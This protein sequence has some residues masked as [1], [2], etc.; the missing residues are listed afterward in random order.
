MGQSLLKTEEGQADCFW[1]EYGESMRYLLVLNGVVSS[2]LVDAPA[3]VL[4]QNAGLVTK[5]SNAYSYLVMEKPEL[6][7]HAAGPL[8]ILLVL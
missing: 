6:L 3:K 4:S 8:A 2:S 5:T 7:P 1:H